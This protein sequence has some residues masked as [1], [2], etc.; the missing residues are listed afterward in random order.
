MRSVLKKIY[1]LTCCDNQVN[2]V[3][4]DFL[5]RPSLGAGAV[6]F[7]LN[8]ALK[9]KIKKLRNNIRPNII[10]NSRITILCGRR[11]FFLG[12]LLER[13]LKTFGIV[14]ELITAEPSSGYSANLH[15]VLCPQIFRTL[16]EKYIVFQ[17]EQLSEGARVWNQKY[18]TALNKAYAVMDFSLENIDFLVDQGFPS[19]NLFYLPIFSKE[20]DSNPQEYKYDIIFYGTQTE[21]RKRI[22]CELKKD[23]NIHVVSDLF[24]QDLQAAIKAAKI[25][26][27]IHSYD[28]G[29]VESPRLFESLSLG[30]IIVSETG[31]NQ[32]EYEYLE[33]I[34]NFVDSGDI[35]KLKKLLQTLLKNSN[36][37]KEKHRVSQVLDTCFDRF[38]FYLAR[39]LF[40][41][42]IISFDN[43][44]KQFCSIVPALDG[45]ISFSRQ[46]VCSRCSKPFLFPT[47]HYF[48]PWLADELTVKLWV[49]VDYLRKMPYLAFSITKECSLI[50]S[51]EYLSM[52]KGFSWDNE[53]YTLT[54][55]EILY[56]EICSWNHYPRILNPKEKSLFE[57][58]LAAESQNGSVRK[59]V[60]GGHLV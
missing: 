39:V 47:L 46:E 24:G 6:R 36:I 13:T 20:F 30:K 49:S 10:D 54:I 52:R 40:A 17:L 58:L 45:P 56:E 51:V 22:L 8:L 50:P 4:L 23:F 59:S 7:F 19:E 32:E 16:P 25:V 9:S 41:Q 33:K 14:T 60:S 43:L 1:R 15:I 37:D 44:S 11:V 2:A 3:I 57:E 29:M 28:G 27:N 26:L 5:K 42:G 18:L 31:S 35:S 53:K 12:K 38:A 34:V 55:S 48:S 21:R